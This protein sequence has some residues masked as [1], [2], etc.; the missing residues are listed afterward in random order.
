M[1]EWV[2]LI[3]GNRWDGKGRTEDID[4]EEEGDYI[5][6]EAVKRSLSFLMSPMT[7]LLSSLCM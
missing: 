7:H 6:E 1:C 4:S 3:P 2:D 5:D